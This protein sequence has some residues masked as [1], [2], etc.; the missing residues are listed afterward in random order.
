MHKVQ[1]EGTTFWYV[2]GDEDPADI[3]STGLVVEAPDPELAARIRQHPD[4]RLVVFERML[5]RTHGDVYYLFWNNGQDLVALD[6]R[7]LAGTYTDADFVA[8]VKTTF[9]E[10]RCDNCGSH[11][12]TLVIPSGDPY[13]GA[14]GL[15]QR[16]IA[17]SK[18]EL[19]PACRASLRQMV[20][21]ILGPVGGQAAG[22]TA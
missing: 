11:W 7:V 12:Q 16:K 21:K 20:V 2:T 22:S 10:T 17:L 9:Q 6:R 8:S 15:L 13:P 19:C 1:A 3:T 14:P 5:K 4:V 18:F